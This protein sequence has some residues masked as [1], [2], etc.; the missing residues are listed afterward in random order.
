MKSILGYLALALAIIFLIGGCTA[1]VGS[2]RSDK[3]AL[4]LARNLGFSHVRDAGRSIW[5][6]ELQGCGRDDIVII[7]VAGVNPRGQHVTLD[8]C[9]GL[10]KGA[11]ARG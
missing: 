3:P 6:V 5:L 7:H 11:T 2:I 4:H 10:L 8:V 9:E 1:G